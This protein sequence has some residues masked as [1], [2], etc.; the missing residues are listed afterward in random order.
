MSS[1]Q[2]TN[3]GHAYDGDGAGEPCTIFVPSN[4]A[5]NNM[6][7]GTLD[8]L[9]SPEVLFPTYSKG[10]MSAPL[11]QSMSIQAFSKL[12]MTKK[13]KKKVTHISLSILPQPRQTSLIDHSSLELSLVF[14]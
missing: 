8:Y 7:D 6:K 9:L 4:E 13:K 1:I 3:M 14:Q 5:L 12:G 10:I 11:P 2:K